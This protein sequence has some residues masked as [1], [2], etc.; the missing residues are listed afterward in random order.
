MTMIDDRN[1]ADNIME[2]LTTL[3]LHERNMLIWDISHGVRILFPTTSETIVL[4]TVVQTNE[5]AR[6]HN[7][8]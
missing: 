8:V 1:N 2:G 3:I 6:T 5:A 7:S 4:E